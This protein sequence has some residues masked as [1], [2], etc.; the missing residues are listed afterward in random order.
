MAQYRARS[1]RPPSPSWRSFLANHV[2]CLASID[3]FVVPTFTF[4]LLY[5]FV[6]L[7]HQRRRVAHC[8]VTGHP[9]A[10]WIARQLQEAFPFEEAPRYLIRDRDA[11]CGERFHECLERMG[12]EEVLIVPRSPWQC[13]CV[14][15]LIGSIR[16]ECLDHLIVFGEAHLQRVL[17]SYFPYY[18]TTRPPLA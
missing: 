2:E 7:C 6:V 16:R 8:N 17:G 18:Q 12:V 11:A 9:A 15:R 14:E 5:A 10:Q 3:F 13:P 4:R 1:T